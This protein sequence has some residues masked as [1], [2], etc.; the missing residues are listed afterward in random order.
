VGLAQRQPA[1]LA[2]PPRLAR[3]E[4]EPPTV[5]GVA[6][7]VEVAWGEDPDL[8]TLLWVAIISGVRRGEL[9]GLRWPRVRLAEGDLVIARNYVQAG[10]A[11]VEKDTKTHQVRRVALDSL[12]VDILRAH[13]ERGVDL[14]VDA[15]QIV[16]VL[17]PN[18][19]G[20]TTLI[21]I[22]E[23]H[24]SRTAGTVQVSGRRSRRRWSTI[25][26][27]HRDRPSIQRRA[28]ASHLRRDAAL[29]GCGLRHPYPSEELLQTVGL[30]HV[31]RARV[32]TLS[33]GQRRR[34]DLALG[35]VGRP[36]LLF[37]D[38]PTTGFDPQARRV[39]WELIRRLRDE[40]VTVLLTTHAMDERRRS[41]TEWW[42]YTPGESWRMGPL[43]C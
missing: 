42:S 31:A 35:L 20:K 24:R 17:G 28:Q 9:C 19:A 21:E 22:L 7:L 5:E 30:L 33:G 25:S 43:A 8:G 38:E 14:R 39:A 32:A 26:G 37:L 10:S 41:R 3:K 29:A 13:R 1:V 6:P 2:T 40:G 4:V 23:G 18:G 34:L 15:G 12:S 27:T 11:L 16:A 36:S